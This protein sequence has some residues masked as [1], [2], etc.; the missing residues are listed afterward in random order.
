[1][2]TLGLVVVAFALLASVSNGYAMDVSIES[3]PPV[4]VKTIPE[5]GATNVDPA[6]SAI[7]VTFSKDML[8]GSY[9]CVSLS[10]ESYPT[11]TGDLK[12]GQDKRT[13]VIPVKLEPGKTYAILFNSEKF[14]N[15][16][17]TKKQSAMA[18]LLV[19]ETKK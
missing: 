1:M 17:D 10:K 16:K 9:S 3:L 4:V 13:F 7:S 19:F 12:L 11:T 6:L 15:F 8:D 14:R 2:K 5:S 18:Y